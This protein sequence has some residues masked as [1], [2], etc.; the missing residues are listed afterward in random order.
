MQ[1]PLEE[2]S[3]NLLLLIKRNIN[4]QKKWLLRIYDDPLYFQKASML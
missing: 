4:K 1:I 3:R 2:K